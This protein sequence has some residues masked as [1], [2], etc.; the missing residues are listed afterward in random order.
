[1]SMDIKARD[2]LAAGWPEGRRLGSVLK[3]ARELQATGLD[4]AGVFATLEVDYPKN[5]Q[6]V[7][8]R[9]TPAPLAEAVDAETPVETVNLAASRARLAELL[10]VPVVKR[11]TLMPDTCPSGHAVATI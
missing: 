9:P 4:L 3:R 6:L 11:G 2:L 8:L 5:A 1:M 10:H 7:A